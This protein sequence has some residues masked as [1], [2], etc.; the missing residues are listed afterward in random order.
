MK[1]ARY[2]ARDPQ[3]GKENPDVGYRND[4]AGAEPA[5]ATLPDTRPGCGGQTTIKGCLLDGGRHEAT[6]VPATTITITNVLPPPLRVLPWK[7]S[8]L[9]TIPKI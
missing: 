6:T 5:R 3:D 1:S 9:R 7:S 8:D 4:I 2:Q